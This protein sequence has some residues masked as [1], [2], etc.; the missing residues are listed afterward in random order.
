[1]SKCSK[2]IISVV[3]LLASVPAISVVQDFQGS[4]LPLSHPFV[5]RWRLELP[6]QSCFEEYQV[7][8]DGTRSVVS[9]QERNESKFVIALQPSPLGFYK[10]TDKI[11]MNNGKPDCFN[12]LTAVGHIAES[13][14]FFSND[15][16]RFL[17]CEQED[18]NT[19]YAEFF[20]MFRE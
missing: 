6:Q 19:C 2:I 14:V 12:S 9:G 15:K 10:W 4:T 3:V 17:L 18:I 13:Y 20:R 16:S 5:G 8:E 1:M 11:T 7:R